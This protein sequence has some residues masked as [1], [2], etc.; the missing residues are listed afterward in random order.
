M[1]KIT[2]KKT[3][4]Y[5]MNRFT[6][7]PLTFNYPTSRKIEYKIK[8][9]NK[10]GHLYSKY[11]RLKLSIQ[12]ILNLKHIMNTQSEMFQTQNDWD[13][14]GKTF[15]VKGGS[16]QTYA[17]NIDIGTFDKWIQ[18]FLDKHECQTTLDKSGVN[19]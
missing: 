15:G 12:D 7:I 18:K 8:S 9:V 11:K 13:Q 1:P 16:L 19:V 6:D 4:E 17:Y 10:E 14:I 2:E 3:V 5:I